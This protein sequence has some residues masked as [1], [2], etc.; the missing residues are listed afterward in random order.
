MA[1]CATVRRCMLRCVL[2]SGFAFIDC[3]RPSS[4]HTT[5]LE[6]M[7]VKLHTSQRKMTRL[8][9]AKLNPAGA[10]VTTLGEKAVA[11]GH[12]G[13]VHRDPTTTPET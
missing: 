12:A 4:D 11:T 3:M 7:G 10:A 9:N 5:C 2:T 8:P 6:Y 13:K 1:G